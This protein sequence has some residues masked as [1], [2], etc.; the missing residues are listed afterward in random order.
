M[1]LDRAYCEPAKLA[2]PDPRWSGDHESGDHESGD[3]ESGD[4][5][6]GDHESGDHELPKL[7]PSCA[8]S[9]H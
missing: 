3:H 4:H 6:S 1:S 5:E 9:A 7:A 2:E 8:P